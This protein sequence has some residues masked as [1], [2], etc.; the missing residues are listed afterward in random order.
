MYCA[1]V[2][3]HI[4][5]LQRCAAAAVSIVSYHYSTYCKVTYPASSPMYCI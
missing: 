4:L 2:H 1:V 5:F 3:S